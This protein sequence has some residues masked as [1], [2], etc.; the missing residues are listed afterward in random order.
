MSEF[1]LVMVVNEFTS[2]G[3][4]RNA[5]SASLKCIWV[6]K[7]LRLHALVKLAVTLNVSLCV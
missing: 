3:V 5:D 4:S 1:F 7:R 6:A 2:F